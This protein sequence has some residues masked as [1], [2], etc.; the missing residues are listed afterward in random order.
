MLGKKKIQCLNRFI[1]CDHF[2]T[3]YSIHSAVD[4]VSVQV[5]IGSCILLTCWRKPELFAWLCKSVSFHWWFCGEE[6]QGWRKQR[7][8]ASDA[9][10]IKCFTVRDVGIDNIL[11]RRKSCLQVTSQQSC[12][13]QL[14]NHS[15]PLPG[16]GVITLPARPDCKVCLC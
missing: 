6:E 3:V 9:I 7:S 2:L 10:V 4:S 1:F 8:W 14:A 15:L 16:Q 5:Q 13:F 12:C 11:S